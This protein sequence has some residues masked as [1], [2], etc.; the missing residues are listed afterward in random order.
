MDITGL[1]QVLAIGHGT[2]YHR[3]H[4]LGADTGNRWLHTILGARGDPKAGAKAGAGS[5]A[6]QSTS[7][8]LDANRYCY[9]RRA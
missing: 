2:S 4:Y 8:H 7:T 5:V 9:L 6:D 3:C 1:S